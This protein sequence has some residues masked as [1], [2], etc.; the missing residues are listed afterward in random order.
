MAGGL[1]VR[2]I[3]F[4]GNFSGAVGDLWL[5]RQ[6]WRFHGCRDVRFVDEKHALA[7][8]SSA[9]AAQAG[10][11]AFA[12]S[13]S[14]RASRFVLR[15]IAASAAMLISAFSMIVILDVLGVRHLT[16]GL[17]QFEL[18]TFE[19]LPPNGP[20]ISV[21]L[22]NIAVAGLLFAALCFFFDRPKP[23]ALDKDVIRLTPSSSKV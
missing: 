1:D 9:P 13:Q 19:S 2:R 20:E 21:D 6:I 15:W 8:Y 14:A 16:I 23:P 3:A 4:V 11:A 10:A 5:V 22:S 7:V 17:S 12:P 18:F